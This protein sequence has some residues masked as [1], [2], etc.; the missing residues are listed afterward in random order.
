MV[1]FR[2]IAD[3]TKQEKQEFEKLLELRKKELELERNK[4]RE[5]EEKRKAVKEEVKRQVSKLPS[6]IPPD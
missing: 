4:E 2:V 6:I 3:L 1:N 5:E